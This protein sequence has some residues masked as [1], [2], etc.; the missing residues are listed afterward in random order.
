M[1]RIRRPPSL[2]RNLCNDESDR[3]VGRLQ[4]RQ[5]NQCMR[6]RPRRATCPTAPTQTLFCACKVEKDGRATRRGSA[7]Q[8]SSAPPRCT[9]MS[10][11]SAPAKSA[12]ACSGSPGILPDGADANAFCTC[13]VDKMLPPTRCSS[14]PSISAPPR[15][16]SNALRNSW[17]RRPSLAP[18]HGIESPP[19]T[20]Q[21]R[22]SLAFPKGRH[23]PPV[24]ACRSC[25]FPPA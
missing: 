25:A 10:R 11:P 23:A 9:S 7:T 24:P 16:T 3:G 19:W 8:C 15:C 6:Q 17:T 4:P 12:N 20:R 14:T 13:A 2:D 18:L 1:P 21:H 5:P 22:L